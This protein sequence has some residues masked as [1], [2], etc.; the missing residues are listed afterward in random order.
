MFGFKNDSGSHN[1]IDFTVNDISSA[2]DVIYSV[3]GRVTDSAKDTVRCCEKISGNYVELHKKAKEMR[4]N[5][6]NRIEEVEKDLQNIIDEQASITG[7]PNLQRQVAASVLTGKFSDYY[8]RAKELNSPVDYHK[9]ERYY[10]LERK[11]E[12]LEQDFRALSNAKRELE[13]IIAQCEEA[14]NKVKDVAD[15]V[16]DAANQAT[17]EFSRCLDVTSNAARYAKVAANA[18]NDIGGNYTDCGGV[19]I[20][21]NRHEELGKAALRI[22]SL[23]KKMADATAEQLYSVR[24]SQAKLSDPILNS[25]VNLLSEANRIFNRKIELLSF[26]AEKLNTAS[27]A[28]KEYLSLS[29]VK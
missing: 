15:T 8:L 20:K 10:Q 12:Y 4:Q 7:S 9:N 14:N 27:K 25:G 23:A 29:N 3:G 18:L 22:N 26:K 16:T 24:R 11:K 5:V 19:R 21:V 13:E 28:L 6:I 2:A 1:P 17:A